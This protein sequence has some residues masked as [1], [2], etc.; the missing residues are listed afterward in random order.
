MALKKAKNVIILFSYLFEKMKRIENS[1]PISEKYT[2]VCRVHVSTN[3]FM[4]Y[5]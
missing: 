1:D 4:S 5:K 2:A 3:S